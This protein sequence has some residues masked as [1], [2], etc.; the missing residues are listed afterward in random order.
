LYG[1][2]VAAGRE[3]LH[4]AS[5]WQQVFQ[6]LTRA[7]RYQYCFVPAF[8]TLCLLLT[9][10]STP[11][12]SSGGSAM[13]TGCLSV[14]TFS[15]AVSCV[16]TFAR[17]RLASTSVAVRC[18]EL[19]LSLHS[20]LHTLLSQLAGVTPYV[21]SSPTASSPNA[22]APADVKTAE[23]ASAPTTSST[24]T[25]PV[26]LRFEVMWSDLWK[27]LLLG[28][29]WLCLHGDNIEKG[30]AA[31]L[32][33]ERE[34]VEAPG[35]AAAQANAMS[36]RHHALLALQQILLLDNFAIHAK[37]HAP[38]PAP[39]RIPSPSNATA[40]QSGSQPQ[41]S[42]PQ[43][44]PSPKLVAL[45]SRPV[46]PA[47]LLN[48]VQ[49][50]PAAAAA[51]A[52]SSS[53]T[54]APTAAPSTAT[55]AP[56]TAA[57]TTASTTILSDLLNTGAPVSLSL[58]PV[59]AAD[60]YALFWQLCLDE[61]LFPLWNGLADAQATPAPS[62][63]S[64]APL[65]SPG[66]APSPSAFTHT[67]AASASA[68]GGAA[69]SNTAAGRVAQAKVVQLL[70]ADLARARTLT[71]NLVSK[72]FLRHLNELRSRAHFHLIWLNILATMEK[73]TRVGS[74]ALAAASAPSSSSSKASP[75]NPQA[76]ARARQHGTT[77]AQAALVE[78]VHESLKN[79]ILVMT[80]AGVFD[81]NQNPTGKELWDVTWAIV[82]VSPHSLAVS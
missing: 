58:A 78:S 25:A 16:L 61:L 14:A 19:L 11:S 1:V 13:N 80:A 31:L 28:F 8:Q 22:Q 36:V 9:S 57:S 43:A 17:S 3:Q 2:C 33:R 64:N 5:H 40:S 15:S 18:V 30:A 68:L 10:S 59:S 26:Q 42:T 82:D 70:S 24:A 71:T 53:A 54:A 29:G 74:Q 55:A 46:L 45:T 51:S 34:R 27:P 77:Q 63:T 73:Y 56:A 76:A 23:P 44:P 4:S 20:H 21:P 32:E 6:L 81:P 7:T 79:L 47:A 12:A 41:T 67:A 69:G 38:V 72:L 39:V 37:L 49:L 65:S 48:K 60:S 52:S 35:T 50:P 66:P 62:I 75:P